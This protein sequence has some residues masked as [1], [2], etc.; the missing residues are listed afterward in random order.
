MSVILD[1]HFWVRSFNFSIENNLNTIK[2][3]AN[4]I[5]LKIRTNTVFWTHRKIRDS[6]EL[7]TIIVRYDLKSK[8]LV[9][10]VDWIK[11]LIHRIIGSLI[12]GS[13]HK[14]Y[15]MVNYLQKNKCLFTAIFKDIDL[16]GLI[17]VSMNL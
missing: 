2:L 3:S 9:D 6:F 7:K 4:R 15:Y 17:L 8:I 10:S 16:M 5:M 12:L 14:V 1:W 11:F 13:S